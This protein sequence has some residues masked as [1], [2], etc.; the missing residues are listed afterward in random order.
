MEITCPS[1]L[2]GTVRR[3][4]VADEAIVTDA[5]LVRSGHM[6]TRLAAAVWTE[7]LDPGPYTAHGDGAAKPTHGL[8]WNKVATADVVHIV[9][10]ARVHSRGGIYAFRVPCLNAVCRRSIEREV[11]LETDLPYKAMNE[12]MRVGLATGTW[13]TLALEDGRLVTYRCL[14]AEDNSYI[15]DVQRKRPQDLTILA[16]ARRV[17]AIEG[18]KD[19]P[20]EILRAVRDL[21]E[22][23]G[24]RLREAVDGAEGGYQ[25]DV[26]LTCEACGDVREAIVPLGPDFFSSRKPSSVSLTARTGS[27]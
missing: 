11:D 8:L 17:I 9:L 6:L 10:Q 24:E 13:P 27:G 15:A 14:L 21:D 25:T 16:L 3:F 23:E 12:E 18:V 19:H 4:K 2:R 7:T 20:S 26:E 1:G 22:A 5:A